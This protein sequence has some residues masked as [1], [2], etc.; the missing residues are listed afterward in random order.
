MKWYWWVLIVGVGAYFFVPGAALI[1][2]TLLSKV[3][4][5]PPAG[6]AQASNNPPTLAVVK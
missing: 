6:L 3:G 5:K 2:W 1:F 4:I